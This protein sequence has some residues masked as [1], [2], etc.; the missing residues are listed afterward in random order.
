MYDSEVKYQTILHDC[1]QKNL[2]VFVAQTST[3]FN[4][5]LRK[6]NLMQTENP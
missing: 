3:A 6:Q 4:L 2:T 5:D 1:I